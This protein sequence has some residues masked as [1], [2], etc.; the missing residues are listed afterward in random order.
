MRPVYETRQDVLNAERAAATFAA[1]FHVNVEMEEHLA[2][3]DFK[4][5]RN[6]SL[7]GIMEFKKRNIRYNQYPDIML[8]KDKHDAG[9]EK[10]KYHGV[11]FLFLVELKDGLYLADITKKFPSHMGGRTVQTRDSRDIEEVVDIPMY[12]FKEII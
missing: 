12:E 7:V 11:K 5:Y 10:A 2:R 9:L 1:R 4:L 3:I 6:K 8:S